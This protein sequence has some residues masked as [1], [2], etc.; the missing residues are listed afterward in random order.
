M[1]LNGVRESK[2]FVDDTNPGVLQALKN[3]IGLYLLKHGVVK[4]A[5]GGAYQEPWN[6]SMGSQVPIDAQGR[7][8]D[9]DWDSNKGMVNMLLSPQKSNDHLAKKM[10][11]KDAATALAYKQKQDAMRHGP[12]EGPSASSG[13][14]LDQILALHPTTLLNHVAKKMDDAG[15]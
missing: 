5:G 14:W 12:V 4:N 7:R 11:F 15:L 9:I 13:S 3:H 2:N 10:G 6:P 1:N 8:S